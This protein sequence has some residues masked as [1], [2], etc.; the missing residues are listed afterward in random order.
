MLKQVLFFFFFLFLLLFMATP[1][2]MWTF[3]RLGVESEL[4]LLTYATAMWNPSCICKLYHSSWQCQ[5]PTQWK[6]P[7]IEPASSWIL[8]GFFSA[9]PQQELPERGS[10]CLVFLS[11]PS[12]NCTTEKHH[13]LITNS[14]G[15]GRWGGGWGGVVGRK[16]GSGEGKRYLGSE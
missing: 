11:F 2:G 7:E 12:S 4:Q 15:S 14:V 13:F 1:H 9:A 5:I 6:R 3:P 16:Q 8:V 10:F